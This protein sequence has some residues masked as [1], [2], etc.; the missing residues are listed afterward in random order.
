MLK[1]AGFSR[2]EIVTPRYRP[3]L[4][5]IGRAVLKRRMYRPFWPAIQ[6]DRIVVHAWR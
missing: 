6:N 3:L 1:A 5:R 2:V 4:Y